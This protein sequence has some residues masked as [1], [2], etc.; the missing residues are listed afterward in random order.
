MN[1]NRKSRAMSAMIQQISH[2]DQALPDWFRRLEAARA[3]IVRDMEK[4]SLPADAKW[5]QRQGIRSMIAFP[6]V[7]RQR[8]SGGAGLP[9]Y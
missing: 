6:I 4:D 3:V 7:V 1:Q 2:L 9:V 8:L 5:F